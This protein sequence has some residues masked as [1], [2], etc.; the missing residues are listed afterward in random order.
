MTLSRVELQRNY[1]ELFFLSWG[2]LLLPSFYQDLYW[3]WTHQHPEPLELPSRC[4]ERCWTQ[5]PSYQKLWQ[6]WQPCD[7]TLP[8]PPSQS[9]CSSSPF[10]SS[11]WG[12]TLWCL[13]TA[14]VLLHLVANSQASS[15][16]IWSS[17]PNPSQHNMCSSRSVLLHTPGRFSSM[18]HLPHKSEANPT[19]AADHQ[20]TQIL[21]HHLPHKSKDS[22]PNPTFSRSVL[23]P[24]S[25]AS[26]STQI[27]RFWN[28]NPT[29]H[30]VDQWTASSSSRAANS[31]LLFVLWWIQA[32]SLSAI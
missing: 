4:E 8:S 1:W 9:C 20:C 10:Q 29:Q 19:C 14:V 23:Q 7:L 28:V 5:W 26:S 27:W 32:P 30:A 25:Q 15:T 24:D 22:E 13:H 18:I 17:Q 11:A 3:W 21:R 16:Q 6:T 12:C 31:D 2:C